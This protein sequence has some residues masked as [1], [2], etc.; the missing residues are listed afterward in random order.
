MLSESIEMNAKWPEGGYICM[1]GVG[2][3]RLGDS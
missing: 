2:C 1:R 3:D